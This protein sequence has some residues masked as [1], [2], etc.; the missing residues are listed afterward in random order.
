[1]AIENANRATAT[2]FRNSAVNFNQ[3]IGHCH[4]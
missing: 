2:Y 3:G 1:M 4:F